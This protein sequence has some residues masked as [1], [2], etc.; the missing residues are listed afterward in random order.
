LHLFSKIVRGNTL[1]AIFIGAFLLLVCMITVVVNV[2][3]RRF[4]YPITGTYELVGLFIAIAVVPAL[5]YAEFKKSHVSIS[6]L[7]GRLGKKPEMILDVFLSLIT[8]FCLVLLLWSFANTIMY[9]WG[10]GE[11]SEVLK[12]PIIPIRI[13]FV[14][15][16]VSWCLMKILNLIKNIKGRG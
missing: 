14:Y 16:L 8:L 4:G 2:V 11:S 9:N 12:F 6:L 3:S 13:F 1:G 15:G 7:E 10:L 5:S